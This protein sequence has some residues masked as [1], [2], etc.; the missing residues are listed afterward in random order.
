MKYREGIGGNGIVAAAS[1]LVL[2][3]G[4]IVACEPQQR[5]EVERVSEGP[6]PESQWV[7]RTRQQDTSE[8]RTDTAAKQGQPEGLVNRAPPD[9]HVEQMQPQVYYLTMEPNDVQ[10]GQAGQPKIDM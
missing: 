1:G 3:A 5:S 4:S 7:M 9:V 8:E 10:L 6:R 2:V